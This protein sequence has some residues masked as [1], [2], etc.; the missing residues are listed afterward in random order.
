VAEI[1]M[2]LLKFSFSNEKVVPPEVK[3]IESETVQ[4]M[5]E[6]ESR[7]SGILAL[8]PIHNIGLLRFLEDIREAGFELVNA[9]YQLRRADDRGRTFHMVRYDFC[10][11]DH[12]ELSS[13]FRQKREPI[14]DSLRR[15]CLEAAWRVRAFVNPFFVKGEMV[16][17]QTVA[18]IN[19]EARKPLIDGNGQRIVAWKKDERGNRV[20]ASPVPLEPDHI[21]RLHG[22][23]V[24]RFE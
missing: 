13:E 1:R 19:L 9:L 23:S 14:E 24:L 15:I 22:G 12:V 7:S 3:K 16:P 4:E 5:E 6:R 17:G 21:L 11:R 18:V 2:I 8:E 20:G 10:H